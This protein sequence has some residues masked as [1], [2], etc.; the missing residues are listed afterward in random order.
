[1]LV[2]VP[3]A[4]IEVLTSGTAGAAVTDFSD[5]SIAHPESITAGPD[6]ALWFTNEGNSSIGRITAAGSITNYTDPSISEPFNITAGPDGALWFTNLGNHSIGR[7]TTAGAISNYSDPNYSHYSSQPLDI[8]AGPDGALWFTNGDHTIGRIT[9]TGQ[10]TDY[11]VPTSGD[12]DNPYG[13]AAGSDGAVWYTDANGNA[14]GRITTGGAVTV[15]TDPIISQPDG[16]TAGPDGALWFSNEGTGTIGRITTDGA[17]SDFTDPSIAAEGG[18]TAGSDGALWFDADGAIGRITVAGHFTIYTDPS[19]NFGTSAPQDITA[20]PDGAMWFAEVPYDSIGRITPPGAVPDA[21]TI[22][23]VTPGNGSASVSFTPGS[24]GG[25]PILHFDATC[26]SSS[27]GGVTRSSSG[28][29][30]P[31]LVSGMTNG[32]SY[33]CS[34]TATNANGTSGS[35]AASNQVVPETVPS[36]PRSVSAV[37]FG[38][39]VAKLS[40]RLPANTGGSAIT[41]YVVKPLLGTLAQPLRTFNSGAIT[42][43]I[44]G[45]QSGRTYRF[46][47]AAGNAVGIGPFSS[48]TGAITAGAPGQPGKPTVMKVASGS[49]RVAFAAPA[50]DGATIIRYVVACASSNGGVTRDKTAKAPLSPGAPVMVTGLTSGKNYACTV[51]ATNGRGTGP[52]SRPSATVVA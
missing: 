38:N 37:P 17:V 32:A 41:R 47:V 23:T 27:G 49:L 21:P 18:I 14:I 43:M 24:D 15:Y 3:L 46:E 25:S 4:G 42:E 16:I 29:A 30:S 28:A 35:S 12:A 10:I 45:L 20:G 34:T 36:A 39:R 22:G 13:I 7:I 26:V 33:T 19:F 51:K 8:T 11:P 50:N 6:G 31:I 40:W 52:A 5:P 48:T 44:G 1:M 9:T 2:A